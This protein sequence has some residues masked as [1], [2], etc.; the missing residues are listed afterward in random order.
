MPSGLNATAETADSWCSGVPMGLPVATSQSRA[1]LVH[2]PGQHDPAVGAE[3]HGPDGAAVRFEAWPMRRPVVASQSRTV[4][5]P[6]VATVRPSGLKATVSTWSSCRQRRAEGLAGRRVPEPGRLVLAA[7]QDRLAV[8]AERHGP[9]RGPMR[10]RLAHRLAGGDVPEPGPS[11]PRIPSARVFPSGLK[12][13]L[14][15][16]LGVLQRPADGLAGGGV[17]QPGRP[18]RAAGREDLAVRAEGHAVD[19]APVPQGR[20]DG[21]PVAASQSCTLAPLPARTRPRPS[22]RKATARTLVGYD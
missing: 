18:V 21:W 19:L 10:Q 20:A 6:A 1:H 15:D 5:P 8:R 9:D 13:T 4:L 14:Q 3:G 22:G 7:G 2:A 16:R 12:A 17:P 11:G